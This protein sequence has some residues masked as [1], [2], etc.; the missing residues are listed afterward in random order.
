MAELHG[1]NAVLV[2][3]YMH[4]REPYSL[5]YLEELSKSVLQKGAS[6]EID[7]FLSNGILILFPFVN[8]DGYAQYL[9]GDL[10]VRKNMN[11]KES[12]CSSG[13]KAGVDINRNFPSSF[14]TLPTSGFPCS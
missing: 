11:T 10:E 3:S 4:A 13:G 7:Y 1:R 5:Q 14:G 12:F 2:D 9:K 6:N 8:P